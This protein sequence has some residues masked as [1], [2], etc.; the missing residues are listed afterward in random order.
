[1]EPVLD[2]TV[3]R[4][5]NE[6]TGYLLQYGLYPRSCKSPSLTLPAVDTEIVTQA[7]W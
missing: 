5:G 6:T 3:D 7:R 2:T 4:N 1:M